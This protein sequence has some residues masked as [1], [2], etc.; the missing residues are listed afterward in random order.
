MNGYGVGE[1]LRVQAFHASFLGDIGDGVNRNAE[2][3]ELWCT[4]PA[5]WDRWH[6]AGCVVRM[7]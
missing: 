2:R 7:R 1:G 3:G 5:Q 6:S 4:G